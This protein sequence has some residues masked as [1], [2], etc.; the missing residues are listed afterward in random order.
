ML[1]GRLSDDLSVFLT[2]VR[3]SVAFFGLRIF[4]GRGNRSCQAV[5]LHQAA[6]CPVWRKDFQQLAVIKRMVED[7]N[8]D[9]NIIGVHRAEADGLHELPEYL[10]QRRGAQVSAEPLKGAV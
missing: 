8:V 10:P 4:S 3:T 7:L 9:I 6:C 2:S 1:S 5:Q